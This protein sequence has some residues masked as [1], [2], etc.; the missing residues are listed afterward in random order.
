MNSSL[1]E[2]VVQVKDVH[3][4]AQ[5]NKQDLFVILQG[6]TGFAGGFAGEN[7]DPFGSI[8]AALDV[9]G[10][11][12]K[13]KIGSLKSI[14]RKIEK[15]LTFGEEYKALEDSSDLD[16]DKMDIGS[17]PELMKVL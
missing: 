4:K 8:V 5:F 10:N 2:I 14:F 6:A 17:V 12:V 11:F 1:K 9:A 15:W 16:F 13:C 7:P 3:D